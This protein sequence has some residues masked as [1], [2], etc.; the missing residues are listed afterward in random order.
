LRR[1]IR[2][3]F[4]QRSGGSGGGP[5]THNLL[6]V[7][8]TKWLILTAAVMLAAYIIEDIHVSGFVSAFFAAAAI[9]VLNLFFRP[10][11]LVLTL[12]INIM[13]LGLFTFVI[14]ALMLKL[15]S[16]LIPGE[17]FVVAGFWSTVFGAIVIS[18]VSWVLNSLLAD[19]RGPGS[20]PGPGTGSG[21]RRRDSEHID[22]ERKGDRW[23]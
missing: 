1:Q 4:R 23:E 13:T 10:V 14:N 20:G 5:F 7:L 8:V 17:H 21:T 15:A 3:D 2:I 12:P 16:L 9:G 6:P 22:L 18:A 19:A 11:L